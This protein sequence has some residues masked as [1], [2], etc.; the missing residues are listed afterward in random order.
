MCLL[1]VCGVGWSEGRYEPEWKSLDSRPLPPWYDEAKVGIF[2]HWGV[3]SVPSFGSEWF[4]E[5]WQGS[6]SQKYVDFMKNNYPPNFS[7][8]D[9]GP[10]FTAEF[11][12]PKEWAELFNASGARYVVLTTKHHEGFTL[13]PSKH[14][15]GWNSL[16]VGPKRD[17]LGES[18]NNYQPDVIWSDG[19]WE[20]F[21][22]YWNATHFLAWLFNDSPVN[23]TVVV[24]D[25]WGR[26]IPCHHG[27]FYTCA[28]NYN[29]GILQPHKWENCLP[30]DRHSWGFRREAKLA[31]L[32]TIHDLLT[33]LAMTVSCGG[34]I[35]I[36]VGPTRD[37]R[38]VPVMEERLRQMGSWLAIN[39]EAIYGSK[40]W[41]HQ[42]D[43]LTP[44]HL[45]VSQLPG[46]ARIQPPSAIL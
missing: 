44:G 26:G 15:W 19:D 45:T 28:D 11:Y 33:Q 8:Q 46:R 23:E 41:A 2:L 21:D 17:L 7:Y 38:I 37:G 12:D 27:S 24:N 43:T 13:W 20:A 32:H 42:N 10:Q 34:N 9:F 1:A 3:F 14:S 22:K 18:V 35:L 5:H 4:W 36:N 39:G 31:D 16:D 30:V 6:K 29:P 25:R 40:P